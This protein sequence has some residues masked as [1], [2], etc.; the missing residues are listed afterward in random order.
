MSIKL[1]DKCFPSYNQA[2]NY[3]LELMR[4][5]R[6]IAEPLGSP[7]HSIITIDH[8]DF[9]FLF[10]L[11][12]LHHEY[13]RKLGGKGKVVYAFEFAPDNGEYIQTSKNWCCYVINQ[14]GFRSKWSAKHIGVKKSKRKSDNLKSIFRIEISN[15]RNRFAQ[16]H[17]HI[18]E[19]NDCNTKMR[20]TKS[21]SKRKK[22]LT[23]AKSLP[24][25]NVD[26]D[27]IRGKAFIESY[28][29]FTSKLS[30]KDV[31]LDWGECYN[32]KVQILANR[33]L[34]KSWRLYHKKN[35]VFRFL[36]TT[37]NNQSKNKA[38]RKKRKV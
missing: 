18:V 19:C 1:G 22:Q 30:L 35:T 8:K 23:R 34:A 2:R 5:H 21:L 15:Q 9:S 20:N 29:S 12:N 4:T 10:N 32:R 28:N 7:Y 13:E 36:C 33:P 38:P 31:E 6:S 26:H 16:K 17:P 3:Q 25:A 14:E 24:I 37:C 27:V 11:F